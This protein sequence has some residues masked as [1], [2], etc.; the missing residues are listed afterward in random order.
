MYDSSTMIINSSRCRLV[1]EDACSTQVQSIEKKGFPRFVLQS[2][3]PIQPTIG[4]EAETAQTRPK[5][6]K[7]KK[8]KKQMPITVDRQK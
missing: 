3:Q 8:E 7:E 1:K 5:E 4:T 2:N 6:R